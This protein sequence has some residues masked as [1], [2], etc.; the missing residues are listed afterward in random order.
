MGTTRIGAGRTGQSP[1]RLASPLREFCSDVQPF[2]REIVEM[3]AG[4][5]RSAATEFEDAFQRREVVVHAALGGA[6]GE[7]RQE[8]GG[9]GS[10]TSASSFTIVSPSSEANR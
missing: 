8:G 5:G 10:S 4:I 6:P 3:S 7:L 1:R 9:A 2:S